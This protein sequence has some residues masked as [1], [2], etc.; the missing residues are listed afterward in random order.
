MSCQILVIILENKVI[1]K[2]MSS[3]YVNIIHRLMLRLFN[4]DNKENCIFAIYFHYFLLGVLSDNSE[5]TKQYSL[6]N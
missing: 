6:D 3:K 1:Q 4:F 5:S 2:L